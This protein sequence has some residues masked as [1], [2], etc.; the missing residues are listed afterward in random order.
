MAPDMRKVIGS[1]ITCKASHVIALPECSKR[2]GTYA[3]TKILD[4]LV[5]NV[6]TDRSNPT[7][8]CQTYIEGDFDLGNGRSKISRVH[9]RFVGLK[10]VPVP[11]PRH[12]MYKKG[13][14]LR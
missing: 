14:M 3:K 8:R 6:I 10:D 4:G 9:I 13:S 11:P 5:T 1:A 12:P 7:G 2:Y